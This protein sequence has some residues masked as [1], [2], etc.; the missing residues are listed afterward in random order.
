MRIPVASILIVALL[1]CA[2]PPSKVEEKRSCLSCDK[3]TRVSSAMTITG[4]VT[5][6]GVECPAVRGDDGK[7][8]TVVGAGREKLTPG[9]RVKITG[10]P[11]QMSTC[12]QGIT[13]NATAVDVLDG[14]VTR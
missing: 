12:M 4:I 10:E 9:A 3:G 2:A 13:I 7:L 11:A 14:A 6:E 8:Y 5:R 1:G